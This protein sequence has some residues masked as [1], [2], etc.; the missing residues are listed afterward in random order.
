MKNSLLEVAIPESSGTVYSYDIVYSAES[1]SSDLEQEELL[2]RGK[3]ATRQI[4]TMR[5]TYNW[6][7]KER[8]TIPTVKQLK[9]SVATVERPNDG[10]YNHCAMTINKQSGVLPFPVR[11]EQETLWNDFIRENKTGL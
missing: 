8:P 5:Q 1:V 3:K 2:K 10:Y 4:T 7:F 11:Y 9:N 6:H